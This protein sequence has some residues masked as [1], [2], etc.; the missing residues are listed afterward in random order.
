VAAAR[1]NGLREEAIDLL[2]QRADASK[3]PPEEAA[4]VNYVR[5]LIRINR[6]DQ[7][8]FDALRKKHGTQWVVEL[9]ASLLFYAMPWAW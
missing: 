8:A 3:F 4:I 9:T 5:Q 1:R 2:R 7:A 6:A